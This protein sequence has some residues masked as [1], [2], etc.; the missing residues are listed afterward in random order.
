MVCSASSLIYG[1]ILYGII[2]SVH[3]AYHAQK[4]VSRLVYSM[5]HWLFQTLSQQVVQRLIDASNRSPVHGEWQKG[6]VG[7]LKSWR[8]KGRTE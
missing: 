5:E 1:F 6:I 2:T 7:D 8:M 4:D 3:N